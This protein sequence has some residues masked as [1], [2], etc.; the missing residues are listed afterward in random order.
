MCVGNRKMLC[1]EADKSTHIPFMFLLDSASIHMIAFATSVHPFSK[2][3]ASKI[4]ETNNN[5]KIKLEKR[6]Q[7]VCFIV[8]TSNMTSSSSIG[9][10]ES[11]EMSKVST[12][13]S[14]TSIP[15]YDVCR[16]SFY[17]KCCQMGCGIES[18]IPADILDYSNA[19][20]LPREVQFYILKLS[21]QELNPVRLLNRAYFVDDQNRLLPPNVSNAF[22]E[23]ETAS[24]FFDVQRQGSQVRKVMICTTDWLNQ[25]YF[26]SA[27][28]MQASLRNALSGVAFGNLTFHCSHC[29]RFDADCTCKEGGYPPLYG[30]CCQVVHDGIVCNGCMHGFIQ[31]PRY[32]CRECA[33]CDLCGYCYQSCEHD[34]MHAFDRIA[35]TGASPQPL[36]ARAECLDLEDSQLQGAE[37]I[38][39]AI[40]VP[41][42]VATPCLISGYERTR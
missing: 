34:Q 30:S 7:P 28:S 8:C 13:G 14:A 25:I 2:K 36:S 31:G 23:I 9:Q 3:I 33:D 19:Q 16:L 15:D 5:T 26:Q 6:A 41:I 42:E 4:E 32:R 11:P 24:H 39:V 1:I 20:C 37:D 38:P 10:G 29:R 40:A 12:Y 18:N 35:R 17:L 21:L 27:I 22:Y